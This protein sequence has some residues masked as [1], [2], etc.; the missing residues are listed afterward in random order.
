MSLS[1]GEELDGMKGYQ[2]DLKPWDVGPQ[3]R[4]LAELCL[5]LLNSNEFRY[6]R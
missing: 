3:T 2:R 1:G 4:A 6:L 5:M